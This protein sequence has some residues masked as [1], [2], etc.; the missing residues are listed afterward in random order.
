[1]AAFWNHLRRQPQD[2]APFHLTWYQYKSSLESVQGY[3][4]LEQGS[5]SLPGNGGNPVG[6]KGNARPHRPYG[7]DTPGRYVNV[8]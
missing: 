4:N 5:G 1:M 2:L 7:Q 6:A 3:D 8:K